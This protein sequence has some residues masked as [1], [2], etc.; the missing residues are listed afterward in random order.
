MGL[1]NGSIHHG[2]RASIILKFLF[3]V[4]FFKGC[5]RSNEQR[6]DW[7]ALF[8]LGKRLGLD[9]NHGHAGVVVKHVGLFTLRY[10]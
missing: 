4:L 5:L 6:T 10:W 1:F 7:W 2:L 9:S 8:C 3:L